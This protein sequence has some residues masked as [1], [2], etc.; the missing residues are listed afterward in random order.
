MKQDERIIEKQNE[1]G[2]GRR[3][4]IDSKT[5]AVKQ[6]RNKERNSYFMQKECVKHPSLRISP[7]RR[8]DGACEEPSDFQKSCHALSRNELEFA[9]R[10]L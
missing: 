5:P 2:G 7:Q 6:I 8:S 3:K 4:E 10:E 1:R 9:P